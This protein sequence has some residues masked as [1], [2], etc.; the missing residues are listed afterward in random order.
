MHSCS[1]HTLL[2]P[3]QFTSDWFCD[4]LCAIGQFS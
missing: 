4:S 3:L 2:W 1:S